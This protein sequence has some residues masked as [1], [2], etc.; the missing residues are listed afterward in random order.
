LQISSLFVLP[1]SVGAGAS[2]RAI[3]IDERRLTSR[4]GSRVNY[5]F[6]DADDDLLVPLTLLMKLA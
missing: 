2:N 5:I 6:N 3:L 4:A 1:G